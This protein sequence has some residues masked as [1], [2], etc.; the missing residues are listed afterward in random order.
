MKVVDT[1]SLPPACEMLNI[2]FYYL[3]GTHRLNIQYRGE[4]A[5]VEGD[6]R[7]Y[8]PPPLVPPLPSSE[9]ACKPPESSLCV[10]VGRLPSRRRSQARGQR[11]RQSLES[12]GPRRDRAGSTLAASWRVRPLLSPCILPRPGDTATSFWKW[13]VAQKETQEPI[14]LPVSC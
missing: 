7:K 2:F 5:N 8:W 1:G 3:P 11:H 12:R 4:R 10:Q 9:F 14:V 6:F 13:S